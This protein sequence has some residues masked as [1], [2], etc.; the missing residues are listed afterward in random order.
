[1]KELVSVIVPI[2]N[3]ESYMTACIESVRSQ[4]YT[5]I[6]IIL[7]D[8]GSSDGGPSICDT[9]KELDA[10]IQVIHKNNGGVSSARNT[11]LKMAKGTYISFIDADDTISHQMIEKLVQAL[12]GNRVELA[13]CGFSMINEAGETLRETAVKELL[14]SEDEALCY[15]LE[16]YDFQMAVWNKLY[17][18]SIIEENQI[19][20]QEQI[21]HGE[22]GLWLC[23]YL[24]KCKK[25]YWTGEPYY[26][27][28]QIESS[29]MHMMQS[30]RK[31]DYRQLSVLESLDLTLTEIKNKHKIVLDTFWA[32]YVG[33]SVGLMIYALKFA[34]EDKLL[35][36]KLKKNIKNY[37]Q[38]FLKS[39]KYSKKDKLTAILLSTCPTLLKSF[40]KG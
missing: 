28:L 16:D 14:L 26:K 8:D 4:T 29:A 22:D 21:T 32:H 10:R 9:Y 36:Q 1:M 38:N 13:V 27:Y 31:F 30:S 12:E 18:R 25:V 17:I 23:T 15:M 33:I 34:P 11:G 40:L 3:A 6:E 2:Y 37:L 5:N 35:I 19:R 39:S 24:T 20:F 7:V